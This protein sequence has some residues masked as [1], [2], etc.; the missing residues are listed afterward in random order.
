MERSLAEHAAQVGGEVVGDGRVEIR[1]VRGLEEA[2]PGDIAF[3][4][5]KKYRR[6]FETTRAAAVIVE[7]GETRAG[8]IPLLAVA[9][10]YLAFAKISTLLH[11]P[12]RAEGGISRSAAVQPTAFVD[13]SAEVGPLVSIGARAKVGARTI[14]RAGVRL[15]EDAVVGADC[16]LHENVV[17]R[18]RCV[19]GDRVILQPGC[20]VGSDGY[21][22]AFDPEGEGQGPRHYKVPQA[23]IVRIEDD[24]ELGACTCVDRATLGETVVGRGSKID[25]LVQI[26]HNVEVGPL[27]LI[28]SQAGI[29][30]STKLG[31]GVVLAGQVGVIGHLTLGDG[32]KVGAQ[33]GVGQ[34]LEPGA[35]VS[36]SPAFDHR[37]WL[38]ASA[39]FAKLPDLIREL[40]R[41]EREVEELRKR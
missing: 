22:F 6:A 32:A 39:G 29:A 23:G 38:R 1:G 3:Y 18:E 33:A 36:G 20:V 19:V 14:L 5:N 13:P 12:P 17:V 24:V 31:M 27:C 9:N 40:R 41:L 7:P 2:G 21:G 16:L 35:I 37:A 11:P 15:A 4:A 28:V 34:D 30:G 10:P 8:A 25:N 26:A